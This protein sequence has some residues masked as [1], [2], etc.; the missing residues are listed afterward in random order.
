MMNL[1]CNQSKVLCPFYC[2]D[3]N[4]P[5]SYIRCEGFLKYTTTAI[6]FTNKVSKNEYIC[7]YCA[8]KYP[9]CKIYRLTNEKYKG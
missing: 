9:S 5:V 4:K 8:D 1:S 7:K 6:E 3:E 2:T